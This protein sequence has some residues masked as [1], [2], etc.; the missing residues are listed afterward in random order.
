MKTHIL[1]AYLLTCCLLLSCKGDQ[2]LDMP[3]TGDLVI[4]NLTAQIARDA[5][6][7]KLLYERAK[8]MY[9]QDDYD[10]TIKDLTAA[11][12]IDS[13]MPQY[14]HLLSDAYLDDLNSRDALKTMDTAS[15][16]FNDRLPTLLKL[17][18]L[19]FILK[20]HE[21]A[22]GTINHIFYLGKED[23]ETFLM[24]GMILFETGQ[25]ERAGNVLKEAVNRD[26][27]LY[28]AWS[29]LGNIAEQ[30]EDP[31]AKTYYENAARASGDKS[32]PLH[33]LA[34]YIQ[35]N[36]DIPGAIALYKRIII[37]DPQYTPAFKNLGVL[38]T[39]IDSLDLALDQFKIAA[40]VDPT[41]ATSHYYQGLL[42]D[43]LGQPTAAKGALE[44]ALSLQPDL[45]AA[46]DALADIG[47]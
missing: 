2:P 15:R 27:D 29:M 6:N 33:N 36:G 46:S 37:R 11:I 42:Y 3:A 13:L 45:Q 30:N 24:L 31:L 9:A 19:Q 28:E 1:L 41:D 5:D 16:L 43:M 18:E 12:A 25:M 17:T 4:D 8:Q 47:R 39:E 38:Y 7:S 40:K 14:Y 32:G 34:F 26:P 10:Q 23:P 44:N 22:L 20:Q 21:K 35:N